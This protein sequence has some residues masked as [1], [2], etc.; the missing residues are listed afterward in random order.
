MLG[1]ARVGFGVVKEERLV[2]IIGS[3]RAG[4]IDIV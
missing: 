1:V 4:I 3:G 2:G